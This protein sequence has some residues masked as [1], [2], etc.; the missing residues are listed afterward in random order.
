MM[1]WGAGCSAWD[2]AVDMANLERFDFGD[3]PDDQF[4]ITTWHRNEPLQEVFRYSKHQAEH[5][6]V[7]LD[8]TL[9]LHISASPRREELLTAYVTA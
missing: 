4:V 1:A 8:Q 9:I 3:V 5:P 7:Q 2:D 6:M